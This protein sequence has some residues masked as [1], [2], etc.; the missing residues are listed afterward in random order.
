MK[1]SSEL[2]KKLQ[3]IPRPI[4]AALT[5]LVVVVPM[6]RPLNIPVP[7]TK[8]VADFHQYIL[9]LPSGS[10]VCFGFDCG[11]WHWVRTGSAAV[12]TLNL[13]LTRDVKIYIWSTTGA[14]AGLWPILEE[15]LTIPEDKEYGVDWVYVGFV[16]GQE[17]ALAQMA[18]DLFSPGTDYYGN[19]LE[20]LPMMEGIKD[21]QDVKLVINNGASGAWPKFYVRQWSSRYGTPFA[22]LQTPVNTLMN[23]PFRASELIN[24]VIWAN[25]GG[26][27]LEA[28][29]GYK[30]WGHANTDAQNLVHVFAILL[31][32]I[33]NI[34]YT[35]ERGGKR[36]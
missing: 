29:L 25:E 36:D 2:G 8:E 4:I 16:A 32:I 18:D 14:A 17:T 3:S 27:E 35:L 12:A 13:L 23:L 30:G 19:K 28:I 9:D 11:T 22:I 26:A 7:I 5:I 10:L 21:W 24:W 33:G 20:D 6:I 31:I 1:M 34:G 15:K